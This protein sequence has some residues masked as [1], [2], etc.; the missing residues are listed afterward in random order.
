MRKT[1]VTRLI[2]L[3][4]MAGPLFR[5][6]AEDLAPLYE[7]GCLLM[8]G[9]PDTLHYPLLDK[10]K[11]SIKVGPAY[12]RTSKFRRVQSWFSYLIA[13][14]RYILL[15]K[16]GDA[17]LLVSNPP[18]L[19]PWVWF[20]SRFKPIPYGILIYDIHPEVLI[21]L[22][23]LA[24]RGLIVKIWRFLNKL[25]NEDAHL[26][27]TIGRRMAKV[28]DMQKS[29]KAKKAVVV[30]AWVDVK[31]ITPLDRAKNPFARD[32][33]E[34]KDQ[35]IVLYSGNMGA[36]HDIDSILDAAKILQRDRTILFIFIGDGDKQSD[37]KSFIQE[38]KLDNILLLPFQPECN[39]KYSLP[40]ADISLVSL[41]QG[42]EDLMMPSKSFYY[43]AAGSAL[44][45]IANQDSELSDLLDQHN[46]GLLVSPGKPLK[47]VEAIKRLA[48]STDELKMMKKS[49]RS[50]A[51][52]KYA[53]KI[54]ISQFSEHLRQAQLL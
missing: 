13:S 6:L 38:N 7:D 23:M 44:I 51:E 50:L 32:I 35:I 42:M 54:C 39:I 30:P 15:A 48:S 37:V 53:R 5:E 11:L 33:P 12:N 46:C 17:I 20:L 26:I 22:G 14:T 52:T 40:V 36:S 49:A 47:L 9:H 8:T 19:G 2:M 10:S 29:L 16:S 45:A 4:Q 1:K 34:I 21:R 27:V 41:D 3:N 18:L 43:L 25:V 31:K 24:E 28:L